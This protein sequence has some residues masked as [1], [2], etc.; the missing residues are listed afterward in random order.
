MILK[1]ADS[2]EHLLN[3]GHLAEIDHLLLHRAKPYRKPHCDD[4]L[5]VP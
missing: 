4:P 2:K 1:Q 3:H 5:N